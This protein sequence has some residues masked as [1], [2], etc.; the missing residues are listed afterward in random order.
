MKNI[1]KI[2]SKILRISVLIIFI[3]GFSLNSLYMLAYTRD[4]TNLIKIGKFALYVDE[5][6][7]MKPLATK[8]DI[9]V[10]KKEQEYEKNDV[11]V[12]KFN[13]CNKIKRIIQKSTINNDSLYEVKGDN[14][15]Y[16]EPYEI[17]NRQIKGRVVNKIKYIGFAISIITSKVLFSINILLLA[18][19]AYNRIKY[20]IRINKKRKNKKQ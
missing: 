20:K 16:I 15:Y 13:D 2:T 19:L 12:Y 11:V 17:S 1:G 3:V 10:I 4:S 14:N 5:D 18:F 9:L 8:N 6:E 7:T